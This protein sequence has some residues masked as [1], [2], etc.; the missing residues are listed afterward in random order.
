M[1]VLA[2]YLPQFHRIDENDA[3]W[4]DGYTEWTAVKSAN[5]LFKGHMQPRVPLHNN[6]Y[7]LSEQSAAAWKW[8]A[9]LASQYGIDGFCIYHYWFHG[10]VFMEK[11]MELLREH[12]EIELPYCICWAN[13][14]F[15]RAW[16]GKEDDILMEQTY[17]DEEEW[18]IH[19]RYL[20]SFFLDERYIKVANK[21]VVHIY[22]SR[23]I[24]DLGSMLLVWNR[25]AREDG[26][27]GIY[28]VS[29]MTAGET[30]KNT[31]LMDAYYLFE[32]GYTLKHRLTVPEKVAYLLSVGTRRFINHLL[33]THLVEHRID[34][35]KIYKHIE[36]YEG[37]EKT[38]QSTL[39]QWDNTP[40]RGAKG[41]VYEN[42]EPQIFAAHFKKLCAKNKD[43]AFLYLN[44][45]NEWGEGAFL[46]PDELYGYSF[47]DAVKAGRT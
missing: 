27:D 22:L 40:R 10:K 41:L 44:A 16:Y 33:K 35:R 28:L 1:K 7:D 39:M 24:K 38:F 13:E 8:Q 21:P 5:P 9:Q 36:A 45:W 4:G 18:E 20:R 26:F 15:T 43:K 11:P 30:D 37:D 6:Y 47:L 32:P 29:A 25:L 19:Y 17:G 2:F 42:A 14:S 12:T 23:D 3:W 34:I 31:D 46:E